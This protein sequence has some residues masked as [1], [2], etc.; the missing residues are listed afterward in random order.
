MGITRE[1]LQRFWPCTRLA[2]KLKSQ[3]FL[4]NF[5][6]STRNKQIR[7]ILET[8]EIALKRP[9]LNEQIESN[10]FLFFV[11]A[12]HENFITFNCNYVCIESFNHHFNFCVSKSF[13]YSTDDALLLKAF[14]DFL[15]CCDIRFTY[16]L[17]DPEWSISTRISLALVFCSRDT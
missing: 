17:S 8:S 10:K 2:R 12:S 7:Q 15:N 5:V 1:N 14:T 6:C 9:S 3:V 13:C 4:E 11:T 16:I